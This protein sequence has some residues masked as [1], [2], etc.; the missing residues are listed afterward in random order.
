MVVCRG[1]SDSHR[2]R[3]YDEVRS[4]SAASL[5]CRR[6]V[7]GWTRPLCQ[8]PLPHARWK[9][10]VPSNGRVSLR[11]L[12]R[13]GLGD[14]DPEDEGGR[15]SSDLDLRFLDSPRG[16]GGTVRLGGTAESAPLYRTLCQ[17]WPVCLDSHWT[18]ESRRGEERR[19]SGLGDPGV[20]H[21]GK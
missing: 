1:P 7:T 9:T 21:T 11:A 6:P 19:D 10:L 12:P 16:G 4:T 5:P 8:Q 20:A 14:R 18:V 17:E 15:D 3:G 13:G 2:H